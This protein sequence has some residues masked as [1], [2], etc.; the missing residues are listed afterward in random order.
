MIVADRLTQ[1]AAKLSIALRFRNSL[2]N[3]PGRSDRENSGL[4]VFFFTIRGNEERRLL[5]VSD[6]AG[7]AAFV[8][9]TLLGRPNQRERITSIQMGIAKQKIES[10]MVFRRSWLRD[11]LDS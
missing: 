4:S 9:A 11:D 6:R 7:E 1:R 3:L 10:A 8:N 5:S 2:L